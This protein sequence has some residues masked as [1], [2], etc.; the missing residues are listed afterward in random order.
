MCQLCGIVNKS[1]GKRV[2]LSNNILDM[3]HYMLAMHS[4]IRFVIIKYNHSSYVFKLMGFYIYINR[5]ISLV[6]FLL[7]SASGLCLP[8]GICIKYYEEC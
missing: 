7:I 8:V 2:M 4:I 1:V 3:L 5:V 6:E